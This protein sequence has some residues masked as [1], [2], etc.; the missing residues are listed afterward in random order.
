[1]RSFHS[2]I[3]TWLLERPLALI[4]SHRICV[5][6]VILVCNGTKL[7]TLVSVSLWPPS[8]R[9]NSYPR[10]CL[11]SIS[12]LVLFPSP[13]A[14]NLMALIKKNSNPISDPRFK[15]CLSERTRG[16]SMFQCTTIPMHSCTL[17]LLYSCGHLS[18]YFAF[19]GYHFHSFANNNKCIEQETHSVVI[20]E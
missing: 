19:R 1:M 15:G 20:F 18:C 16:R 8:S 2:W 3:T 7:Y 10:T 6:L 5:V 14:W 13:R 11:I 4:F 12:I 9:A 17:V